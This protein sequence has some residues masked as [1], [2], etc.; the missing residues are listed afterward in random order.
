MT[1]LL[2]C[3]LFVVPTVFAQTKTLFYMT[4]HPDS[5]R[6]FMEHQT[7]ID[8]IVPTWYSVDATGLVC[9]EPDP[10]VMPAV[11]Q[12]HISIFPIVAIFDKMGVHTL[13]TSDKA[14]MA[15]I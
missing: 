3:L 12:R 10:T 7:K 5:V 9:G 6:D 4:D 15:L 13:L 11:K 14:Q 1:K 2:L 8:I